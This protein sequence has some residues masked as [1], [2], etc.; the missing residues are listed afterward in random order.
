MHG[1]RTHHTEAL[2]LCTVIQYSSFPVIHKIDNIDI[3]VQLLMNISK[4]EKYLG[5]ESILVQM[6]IYH[7]AL[8]SY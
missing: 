5:A 3:F 7:G 2:L 8:N 1:E 4:I 6:D